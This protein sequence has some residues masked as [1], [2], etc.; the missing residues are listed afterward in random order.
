MFEMF[1]EEAR[2]GLQSALGD[3]AAQNA[4][5]AFLDGLRD[6]WTPRFQAALG[7]AEELRG[8]LEGEK[9]RGERLLADYKFEQKLNAALD[10]EGARAAQFQA[11]AARAGYD[12]GRD[13][14]TGV[15]DPLRF[16]DQAR[17]AAADPDFAHFFAKPRPADGSAPPMSRP[18]RG[19][20]GA[21]TSRERERLLAA[22]QYRV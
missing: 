15:V 4:A 3:E 6:T 11:V 5:A 9:R 16:D 22:R 19:P 10:L 1:F 17:R 7:E 14:E 8:A 21:A 13:S 18:G 20:R 12:F 2:S